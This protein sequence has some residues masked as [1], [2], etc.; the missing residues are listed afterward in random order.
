MISELTS[1]SSQHSVP[2]TPP[3]YV[4]TYEAMQFLY[5][6]S[7]DLPL[8]SNGN[9]SQRILKIEFYRSPSFSLL[10]DIFSAFMVE[11]TQGQGIIIWKGQSTGD[12]YSRLGIGPLPTN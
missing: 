7:N 1:S 8:S 6:L 12:F 10:K 9:D 2:F 3:T 4:L 11:S 5:Y